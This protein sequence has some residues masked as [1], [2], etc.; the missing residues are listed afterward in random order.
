MHGEGKDSGAA[1]HQ[2][3]GGHRLG[4]L[5]GVIAEE[6]GYSA[7]C[8]A[9]TLL[10]GLG[11]PAD[12]SR[13]T[14]AARSPAA[15]K[16]RVLLAQALFGKP[17]VLLLDEPTNHLDL[18]SIRWLEG[19][20]REYEGVL[21]TVSHDRHFLNAI[22]THIAD[23]D[24][25][26]IIIYTGNYDDMVRR[27]EPGPLARVEAEN[28]DARRRSPSC[29]TSSPASAPARAPS[30]VQSRKKADREAAVADLKK[31]NIERPFI[32][33]LREA[34]LGQADADASRG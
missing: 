1:R 10:A 24:Y 13:R 2:R 27:Q 28:A 9:A 32:K 20:L 25:K 3:R 19:S 34:S 18:D 6:D 33:L 15:C 31:S 16:L 23:I 21:V 11:I 17:D 8:D 22:C 12:G 26:T 5:E 14:D 4:E 30:Q 29:R 7:E